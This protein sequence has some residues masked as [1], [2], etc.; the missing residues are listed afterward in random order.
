MIDF[1]GLLQQYNEIK[2]EIESAVNRVLASGWYI[3]GEE[4]TKFE[5]EFSQYTNTGYSI[6]V[7]SGSDALLL[8]IM[9]LG[10]GNGDEVLTVSHTFISTVDSIVRSGAKPI[11]IDIEPDTYCIDPAQIE[12]NITKRTKAIIPVHLYGH[13]ANMSPIMEI[14]KKYNLH[15]IEDACQAH[16]AKYEGK[17]L[18]GI[19]D[20]GCFS[21]YPTK[22][23]GAY[24]DAGMVV[25]ND[26]QLADKIRMLRNYGQPQKNVHS[27]LGINSR[28]DEIQ[29]AILRVKLKFLDQW[30][31]KRREIAG[32]YNSL[33]S[34]S[35]IVKPIEK[36]YAEHVYYLYVIR[37][38]QRIL[39]QKHLSQQKIHTQIH[40]PTPVHNQSS[41][42]H[43][44]HGANLPVTEEICKEILSLP[45]H[46]WLTEDDIH[47]IVEVIVNSL[48]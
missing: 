29:S 26:S 46:P 20:I 11:F 2:E 44:S 17:N 14:A 7:N 23:L 22:N 38:K 13:S 43:L 34:E 37:C 36:Y 18:G 47:T 42:R 35:D 6:G 39:L 32:Q 9:A 45:M 40:Y 8:A 30:N 12:Q 24:G 48:K 25:T 28:L 21:F 1:S 19:G 15:V 31:Q 10:I 33:L 16:G 27:F 3:M 41:Y 5:E 4:L